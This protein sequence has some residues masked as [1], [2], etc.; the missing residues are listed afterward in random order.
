MSKGRTIETRT[1]EV[2]APIAE[3]NGV[4]IYDV[5][6]VKE[7][8]D[9][10]LRA[11]IDKPEGVNI[12]DCENVSRAL[13]DKLDEEDFIDDAYILEGSSPGLGRTLKKDKHLEKSL[14][15]EVELRLYKPKD[16]QKE[17]AGILKAFDENSVTIETQEE[18]KVFARSEIALIRLAFDF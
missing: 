11:Y 3:A 6:Y 4:E 2:L 13:S 1:E 12:L 5:E 14:G 9:W 17:F 18:E 7:G 15:E 10:Y 16:K 8:S